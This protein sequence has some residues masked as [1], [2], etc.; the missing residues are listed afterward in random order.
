[1]CDS[2]ALLLRLENYTL[3]SWHF[4]LYIHLTPVL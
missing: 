3:G 4:I 2:I 1:M